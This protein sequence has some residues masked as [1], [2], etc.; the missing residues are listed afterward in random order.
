MSKDELLRYAAYAESNSNHP[1]AVSVRK[2]YGADI[3][4]S[5]ITQCSEIA[6][7][8]IKAVISGVT[9]LCGNSRLMADYSINCPEANGTVLYVAVD[10]KYAGLIEIADMPKE[11]SAEAVKMLKNHGVK[12]VMLTGDNRS[13]AAAAAEKLGITDY[14]AELLPENKSEITLKMKS[15]LPG[16][17]KVMFVGDGI[18]DAPVIASADIGVAMGGTGADSA[19]ETADCVLMKDDPMQLADAFAIS[20]KTNRIVLQNIIFA[21]GVKLIIQVLGVLGLANMWA[22]VFADVGVSIIAIFNSLRLMRK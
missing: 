6:G 2:A 10:N 14:Y 4:Q 12:V 21:L 3:D 16:N 15:E 8:G 5:Q 9:V 20:K 1:I 7:K 19:I 17:E 18:N 22:A 11:H 13:A